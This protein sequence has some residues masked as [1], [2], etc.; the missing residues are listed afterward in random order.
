M[1]LKSGTHTV[2]GEYEII[3]G[4]DQAYAKV[5]K[6]DGIRKYRNQMYHMTQQ[7]LPHDI[8][9]II[10]NSENTKRLKEEIVMAAKM[11]I[12]DSH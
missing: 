10:G 12:R 5:L 7:V 3:E 1:I 9:S 4:G 8:H 2:I 11:C 6:F